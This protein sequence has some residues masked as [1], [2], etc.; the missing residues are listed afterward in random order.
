MTRQLTIPLQTIPA[1]ATSPE[2]ASTGLISIS[3]NTNCSAAS[4]ANANCAQYTLAVP[5]SNPNVGVFSSSG[6]S[7]TAPASGDVF[8]TVDASA[9]VPMS[10]G[11]ADCTP[12]EMTT[13]TDGNGQPLKAIAGATTTVARLD[14]TGCS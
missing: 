8:F 2:V 12:S 13:S 9:A 6:V 10:G 3:S 7:Y 4:P 1:T 5:G 14:F 11:V